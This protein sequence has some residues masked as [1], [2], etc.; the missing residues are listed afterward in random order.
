VFRQT[1]EQVERQIQALGIGIFFFEYLE[2]TPRLP[3]VFETFAEF[4][5]QG[6]KPILASVSERCVSEIVRERNR[7][8]EIFIYCEITRETARNLGNFE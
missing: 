3:I 7:T 2:N 1:V 8:S 4:L 5:Q 6:I